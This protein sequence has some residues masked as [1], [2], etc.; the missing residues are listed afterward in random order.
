GGAHSVDQKQW[1]AWWRWLRNRATMMAWNPCEKV[2][3]YPSV[4]EVENSE[5]IHAKWF[6]AFRQEREPV[7]YGEKEQQLDIMHFANH[8]PLNMR[9][10]GQVATMVAFADGLQSSAF[11]RALRDAVHFKLQVLE[12]AAK[13]ISRLGMFQYVAMHVRRN[14]LQYKNVWVPANTTMVNTRALTKQGEALY[15]ATDET[16]SEFF[17]SLRDRHEVYQFG[18]FT[19]SRGGHA[20][21]GVE[22]PQHLLGPV[23][24]VI[25]A[26]ARIFFGTRLS[27][28]TA[29]I[30]RLRG[31]MQAPDHGVYYHNELNKDDSQVNPADCRVS[32]GALLG[33]W[34]RP[35]PFLGWRCSGRASVIGLVGEGASEEGTI[36][37]AYFDGDPAREELDR[38]GMEGMASRLD[39]GGA[40]EV[41]DEGVGEVPGRKAVVGTGAIGKRRGRRRGNSGGGGGLSGNREGLG[42]VGWAWLRELN[43][44]GCARG[45]KKDV[46]QIIKDRCTRF[47]RAG[48]GG[49]KAG[50][51]QAGAGNGGAAAVAGATAPGEDGL[52]R[53][54][55]RHPGVVFSAYLDGAFFM[56][57]PTP[58]TL[59]YG[60][61]MKEAAGIGLDIQSMKSAA[62]SPEGDASCFADGM[63]AE[64]HGRRVQEALRDLL[65]GDAHLG[66]ALMAPGARKVEESKVVTYG[67]VHPH[68]LVPFGVE[69][70]G[71]ARACGV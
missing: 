69:V 31:Y 3:Y 58:T 60:T 25:C 63:P 12:V 35:C 49:K 51:G 17:S 37:I 22:I 15:I 38:A 6:K 43:A 42:E 8:D 18:D 67:E 33:G 47:L 68:H 36:L 5:T 54:Q 4:R 26:G 28:F 65:P 70:Y 52:K 66:A 14:E 45:T 61:Y 1:P 2:L 16:N 57:P 7:Q 62:L 11:H 20:L 59:A 64:E 46:T 40:M 71:G 9:S 50:I 34:P 24:Q 29:Y 39:S 48:K 44:D 27:T 32:D 53:V 56:D 23:E 21:S 41:E 55:E 13:V 10:F 30:Q 19:T